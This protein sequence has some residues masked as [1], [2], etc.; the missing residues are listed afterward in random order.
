MR[1]K[2]WWHVLSVEVGESMKKSE[3][4]DL[5]AA[6]NILILRINKIL[7]EIEETYSEIVALGKEAEH[8]R[9]ALW[10]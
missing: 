7:D 1:T 3:R 6:Y 9:D 10:K 8:Q 4:E 2:L 5:T